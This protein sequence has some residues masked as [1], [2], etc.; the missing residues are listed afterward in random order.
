MSLNAQDDQAEP[1]ATALQA[2]AHS[3]PAGQSEASGG[4]RREKK[5]MRRGK[6]GH[7]EA[8]PAKSQEDVSKTD[9]SEANTSQVGE[10]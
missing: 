10:A 5:R 6:W 4:A 2:N 7:R 8:S 9:A 1:K 3:P